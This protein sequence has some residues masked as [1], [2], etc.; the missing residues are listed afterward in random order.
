HGTHVAGIIAGRHN[1][2][3]GTSG[4]APKVK[5]MALKTLDENKTGYSSNGVKAVYYAIRN[6]AK[7]INASWGSFN[8]SVAMQEALREAKTRGVLVI[9]ASGNSNNDNDIRPFYPA[10]YSYSNLLSVTAS[11]RSNS[12]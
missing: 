4:V 10:S 7:V 6:G 5:I 1:S 12:W 11:T 9:A 3:R 2:S 8:K